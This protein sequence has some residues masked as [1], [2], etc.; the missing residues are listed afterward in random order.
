MFRF[1]I[2]ILGVFMSMFAYASIQQISSLNEAKVLFEQADVNTLVIFDIDYTLTMPTEPALQMPNIKK[3]KQ[4]FKSMLE[5]F[6][7]EDKRIF[8]ALFIS[9][10]ESLLIEPSVVEMIESFQNSGIRTLA[11]TATLTGS[12]GPIKCFEDWRYE[13]LKKLGIDFSLSF[14]K[15]KS[16]Y[17]KNMHIYQNYYPVYKGGIL[18]CNHEN[19]SK[20]EVL[21]EFLDQIDWKPKK[22][23]FLDDD[24]KNVESMEKA[25]KE[26]SIEHMG[27]HYKGAEKFPSQAIS[28]EDI[29]M[30]WESILKTIKELRE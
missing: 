20:G 3:N 29:R 18:L 26:L 28:E 12:L 25:L 11:L 19:N 7:G 1:I 9:R 6:S 8:S 24:I 22:V 2:S 23:I 14:P 15:V 17:F 5:G 10:A 27:L 30:K 21:K 13:E 4:L 16:I